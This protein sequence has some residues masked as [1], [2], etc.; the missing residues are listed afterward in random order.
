MLCI[1]QLFSHLRVYSDLV[2][3]YRRQIVVVDAVVIVVHSAVVDSVVIVVHAVIVVVDYVRFVVV[4]CRC[5]YSRV[6]A[7]CL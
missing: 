6:P 3:I 7:C 5:Y 1:K 2:R 4:V